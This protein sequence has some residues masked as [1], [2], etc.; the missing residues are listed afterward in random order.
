MAG[1][2]K[3]LLRKQTKASRIVY[4]SWL[5]KISSKGQ[6]GS[7]CMGLLASEITFAKKKIVS[8]SKTALVPTSIEFWENS[9]QYWLCFEMFENGTEFLIFKVWKFLFSLLNG[10]QEFGITIVSLK[11]HQ[12]S[13]TIPPK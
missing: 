11:C 10:L 8:C 5:N 6:I 7:T 12:S 3:G 13:F 9:I 2:F 1:F 4:I